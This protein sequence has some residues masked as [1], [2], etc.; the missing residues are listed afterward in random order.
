MAVFKTTPALD[1][2]AVVVPSFFIGKN[3]QAMTRIGL[4]LEYHAGG[5]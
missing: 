2:Y 4:G 3:S 5:R 1:F